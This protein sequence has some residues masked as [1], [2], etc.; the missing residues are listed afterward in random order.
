MTPEERKAMRERCEA[1][2][3]GPWEQLSMKYGTVDQGHEPQKF[4]PLTA[5]DYVFIRHARSD[6]PACLDALDEAEKRIASYA[7]HSAESVDSFRAL[8]KRIAELE[9]RAESNEV[10][11]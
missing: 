6:L 4:V 8:H 11:K 3:E 5:Y 7:R 1:A 9:G 10:Q 2:T